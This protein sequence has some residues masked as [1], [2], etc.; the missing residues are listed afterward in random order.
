MRPVHLELANA[1]DWWLADSIAAQISD[2]LGEQMLLALRNAVAARC[3]QPMRRELNQLN[4]SLP[5]S[6]PP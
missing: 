6:S 5:G 2:P 1:T 3:L 4:L